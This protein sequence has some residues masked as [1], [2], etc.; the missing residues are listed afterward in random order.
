MGKDNRT[1]APSFQLAQESRTLPY[2]THN[3]RFLDTG[4]GRYDITGADKCSC[5]A[6]ASLFLVFLPENTDGRSPPFTEV[7]P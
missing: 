4:E 3:T 6:L 1:P 2:F 5:S 7:Q